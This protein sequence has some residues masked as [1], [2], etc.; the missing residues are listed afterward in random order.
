M[1]AHVTLDVQLLLSAI[2]EKAMVNLRRK[3]KLS[4]PSTLHTETKSQSASFLVEKIT[5]PSANGPSAAFVGMAAKARAACKL[6]L[7]SAQKS[8]LL[9]P[10]VKFEL[11]RFVPAPP[12]FQDSRKTPKNRTASRGKTQ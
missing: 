9:V 8:P 3:K 6:I 7:S 5:L 4:N 12:S 10:D 11:P 1:V 2:R